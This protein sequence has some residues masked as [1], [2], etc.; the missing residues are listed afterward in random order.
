MKNIEEVSVGDTFQ[1]LFG[2]VILFLV[3]LLLVTGKFNDFLLYTIGLI[4][5][6][7]LISITR[8]KLLHIILEIIILILASITLIALVP[9]FLFKV[10][11]WLILLPIF[12]LGMLDLMAFKSK[13]MYQ[14]IYV[15]TPNFGFKGKPKTKSK[16][17]I[18]KKKG[19][20]AVDAEFSEK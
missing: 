9:F 15:R 1:Y 18:K 8:F 17:S 13:G 2:F 6:Q 14:Q 12:V 7:L 20:G 4:L 5:I 10:L 3:G 16:P 19:E 11:A